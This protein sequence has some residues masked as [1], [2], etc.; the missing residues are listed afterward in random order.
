MSLLMIGPVVGAI[1]A[2]AAEGAATLSD[3][4]EGYDFAIGGHGFRLAINDERKYERAT[5]QFRKEQYD[6]SDKA[7]DQ[8]L[9][10]YWTRGQLSFHKGAGQRFAEL[11][12]DTD[13][14]YWEGVGAN[15]FVKGEVSLY[16][17]WGAATL[18]SFTGITDCLPVGTSGL[19][20]LAD[21][22]IT[23][24]DL[25]AA[26]DVHPAASASRAAHSITVGGGNIY[27][28]M[29]DKTIDRI[30]LTLTYPVV[31]G[32]QGF[33]TD[34]DSWATDTFFATYETA[35]VTR[36]ATFAD[37]GTASLKT[38]WPVSGAT[39]RSNTLRAISG[40]TVGQAYTLVA[41]VYCSVGTG[42]N[43]RGLVLGTATGAAVT[44]EGSWVTYSFTFTATGTSHAIG[45]ENANLGAGTADFWV[46]RAILYRGARTGYDAGGTPTESIYSHT[47]ALTEIHY[48]K[49]RLFVMDTL[50]V[51]YQLAPNPSAALPVAIA[52]ADRV[53]TVTTTDGGW[54]VC[55]TPGPVL[56][57]NGS[58]VFAVTQN[59]DG[60][61][62]TL[63]SPVQVA[64]L[65]IG[66][67]VVGMA[68]YLG[69]VVL[70]TTEGMR[71]AV[72][73]DSTI[74]YGPRLTDWSV[75]PYHTGLARAGESVFIAADSRIFEVNL[76]SQ[77]GDGLEFGWAE[78]PTP[79]SAAVSHGVTQV[80]GRI[81]AWGGSVLDI[82]QSTPVATGYLET[83]F[84]RFGSL[85]P[86]KFHTVRVRCSGAAG[87]VVVAKVTPE[88]SVVPLYTLPA[89]AS[90]TD[91]TLRADEPLDRLAL[92]FTLVA[93]GATS[94]KLLSY[95]LRALPA[96]AR[97]RMIRV[98]LAL[99]DVERRGTTRAT[100][101]PG[102]AWERL[103]KLETMEA[104][105]SIVTYQD[106]RTGES[107]Q[108]YIEQVAH[109][110]NTPPSRQ[111]DGFGGI[112]WVTLRAL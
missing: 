55:D 5:A 41:R 1:G 2:P 33:E 74:T 28:A 22:Q 27:A 37:T 29:S 56:L 43:V 39:D 53:F 94:P 81:V 68:Y 49:D 44:T 34:A 15:P 35:T 72:L 54:S 8:S 96:P 67:A 65:P 14:R 78:L 84:H 73:G 93:S 57:A 110:G 80:D 91:I 38:V 13:T 86:K 16:P 103:R 23:Y 19:A 92:R 95:Q 75:E 11:G 18:D 36:D 64:D 82:Q 59:T 4:G 25:G 102:A 100:G 17:S 89:S 6:A 112:V 48:A 87:S 105:S 70:A 104:E 45:F 85:E 42:A 52:P 50:G 109:E 47:E 111:D 88:G 3:Q 21:G 9:L 62:P 83:P 26:G 31:Y 101:R 58:R 71:V 12:D 24:G 97:Q 90:E 10:G 40:L 69:F 77:I 99:H 107:G 20:V 76:S 61:F 30:G 63:S 60:L 98:P 51:W 7:G 46:D 66:E 32:E 108:C 106:F 79:F